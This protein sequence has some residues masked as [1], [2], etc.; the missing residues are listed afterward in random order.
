[1][2]TQTTIAQ[3]VNSE[4]SK[5][6]KEYSDTGRIPVDAANAVYNYINQNSMALA[7]SILNEGGDGVTQSAVYQRVFAVINELLTNSQ[8][9]QQSTNNGGWN[10]QPMNNGGWNQQQPMN[11]NNW[12]RQPMNTGGWNQQ[13]VNNGGWNQQQPMNNSWNQQQPMNNTNWGNN[14]GINNYGN[15]APSS[16]WG[17]S[18]KYESA[19]DNIYDVSPKELKQRQ[20]KQQV[21]AFDTQANAWS[22]K[23]PEPTT[24]PN[25]EVFSNNLPKIQL[26]PLAGTSES[27]TKGCVSIESKKYNNTK[28]K[29]SIYTLNNIH[30]DE[31]CSEADAIALASTVKN[32]TTD[33]TVSILQYDG[34]NVLDIETKDVLDVHKKVTTLLSGV[35]VL[36]DDP[37]GN[38][39]AISNTLKSIDTKAAKAYEQ[40]LVRN[41][42]DRLIA[43]DLCKGV[44]IGELS[45]IASL[46]H[47]SDNVH[48][49][50]ARNNN[51]SYHKELKEICVTTIQN[52]ILHGIKI[53]DANVP[54]DINTVVKILRNVIVPSGKG[55]IGDYWKLITTASTDKA[56]A[57]LLK[58]VKSALTLHTVISSPKVTILSNGCGTT[59]DFTKSDRY[60]VSSPTDLSANEFLIY[61]GSLM[62]S[63]M[64]KGPKLTI[65]KIRLNYKGRKCTLRY[66]TSNAHGGLLFTVI[67]DNWEF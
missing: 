53:L 14:Q 13:P 5:I 9:Q 6:L 66:T 54:G 64:P 49:M 47:G 10:Q 48:V 4:A 2:A 27:P 17:N 67:K 43:S 39:I 61:E 36:T 16:S 29:T 63:D 32:I 3:Y 38:Y 11:N 59:K 21:K 51:N 7:Q 52:F 24:K 55:T 23:T 45:D 58:E 57:A 19:G 44:T 40:L 41:F 34:V 62:R 37:H 60:M 18:N 26:E 33:K 20:A 28:D 42:N 50:E 15:N 25:N 35:T 22:Q 56:S 31:V 30:I 1:M 12:Q 65:A 8:R 46:S